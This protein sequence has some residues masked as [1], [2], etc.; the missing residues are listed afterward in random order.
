MSPALL[1]RES[2]L[3][4]ETHV[5]IP[6][7][8]GKVA[9]VDIEDYPKVC[10]FTWRAKP[11]GRNKE[12]WYVVS[13]VRQQGGKSKS[14]MMHRVIMQPEKGTNI[15]HRDRNGLDNRRANL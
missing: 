2:V 7:T 10:N 1:A 5:E 15:D 9:L 11:H 13:N 6:L 12:I 14:F 3:F 4:L 8:H